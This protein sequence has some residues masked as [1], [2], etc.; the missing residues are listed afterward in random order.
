MEE[1]IPAKKYENTIKADDLRELL[2][3]NDVDFEKKRPTFS[4][5]YGIKRENGYTSLDKTEIIGPIKI[6][7]QNLEN[8]SPLYCTDV[9]MGDLIIARSNLHYLNGKYRTFFTFDKC[10]IGSISVNAGAFIGNITVRQSKIEGSIEICEGNVDYIKIESSKINGIRIN[11][12]SIIESLQIEGSIAK[13]IDFYNGHI[14]SIKIQ[15][16][17]TSAISIF[18]SQVIKDL[19]IE[20]SGIGYFTSH[21]SSINNFNIQGCHSGNFNISDT[22]IYAFE[23]VAVDCSYSIHSSRITIF[24]L[25]A[26]KIPTLNIGLSC[27]I[28]AYITGGWINKIDFSNITLRKE[29]IITFVDVKVYSIIMDVLTVLGNLHFRNMKIV[30]KPFPW[31]LVV[32]VNILDRVILK[33][34]IDEHLTKKSQEREKEYQ[35]ICE[36]LKDE[37]KKPTLKIVHSSLGKTEFTGFPLGDFRLEFNNSKITDCFISGISIPTNNV[38]IFGSEQN[39]I[40]EHEQKASFFNQFKKIF[41]AQGD[42]YHATQ[43]QAKWAEEQRKYLKLQRKREISAIGISSFYIAFNKIRSWIV[44]CFEFILK[45]LS[46]LWDWIEK[47][48]FW[49]RVKIFFNS[50][51]NDI[52]TLWLNKISN[53]HGESWARTLGVFFLLIVPFIYLLF[54]WRIGRAFTSTEFDCNLIWKYFEFLNPA[55]NIKFI[56]VTKEVNGVAILIDFIGRIIVA[57]GIYQFIAAFRKHTKKQ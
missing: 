31:Y 25:L 44:S 11:F 40:E 42:I 15:D 45:P 13:T 34:E 48:K 50:T 14:N 10:E 26:C 29:N 35:K 46:L 54:L 19:N 30:R 28:E 21:K 39:P 18:E 24:K 51:S 57:Y 41:E 8:C 56:D 3:A 17:S 4:G 49:K 47:T 38:Y 43:F 53:L 32:G 7:N 22:T 27:E 1:N 55:H 6:K 12:K 37:F 2:L 5:A 20:F 52:F 9:K 23:A 16:S 33:K 36:R